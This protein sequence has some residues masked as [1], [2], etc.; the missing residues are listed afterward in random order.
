MVS[1]HIIPV[2]SKETIMELKRVNEANPCRAPPLTLTLRLIQNRRL[3][4]VEIASHNSFKNFISLV[5]SPLP[6]FLRKPRSPQ[7]YPGFR[8]AVFPVTGNAVLPN[9]SFEQRN[10]IY[11]GESF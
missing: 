1:L 2:C 6:R 3:R 5:I 8:N 10:R 11:A 9:K 4:S 7:L